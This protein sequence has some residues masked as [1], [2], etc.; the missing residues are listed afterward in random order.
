MHFKFYAECGVAV[1]CTCYTLALLS[2]NAGRRTLRDSTRVA[3]E[4]TRGAL[5]SPFAAKLN[6]KSA[7]SRS[8]HTAACWTSTLVSTASPVVCR[9]L[10]EGGQ[11]HTATVRVCLG[12]ASLTAP[13]LQLS[14]KAGPSEENVVRRERSSRRLESREMLALRA[15]AGYPPFLV[16]VLKPCRAS[17]ASRSATS[18]SSCRLC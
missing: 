1:T 16:R 5:W 3:V 12:K 4:E 7:D 18:S 6:L 11:E 13:S 8:R 2:S 10:N 15:K 9:A 14:R 17:V